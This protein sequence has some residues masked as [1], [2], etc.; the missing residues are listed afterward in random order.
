M[1]CSSAIAGKMVEEFR[2]LEVL[3]PKGSFEPSVSEPKLK[4][5]PINVPIIASRSVRP[6]RREEEEF[7]NHYKNDQ[8]GQGWDPKVLLVLTFCI[9]STRGR[10]RHYRGFKRETFITTSIF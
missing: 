5:E 2:K 9:K 6:L 8:K 10:G 4:V 7:F 3:G 1:H